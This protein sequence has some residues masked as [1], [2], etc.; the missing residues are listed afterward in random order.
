MRHSQDTEISRLIRASIDVTSATDS[1]EGGAAVK[2]RFVNLM[3]DSFLSM[4]DERGS[5]L[6]RAAKQLK[7]NATSFPAEKRDKQVICF[8]AADSIT[9]L[10]RYANDP[11]KKH[12]LRREIEAV[13]E[14]R[15]AG[16]INQGSSSEEKGE[17]SSKETSSPAPCSS[18][19]SPAG[20]SS[21]TTPE[22]NSENGG[23]SL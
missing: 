17:Q 8:A 11:V 10:I 9:T 13:R 21:L 15:K 14:Q 22:R 2:D 16:G 5:V 6:T 4:S 23:V 20:S 3:L 12:I 19:S 1:E 18:P 7:L